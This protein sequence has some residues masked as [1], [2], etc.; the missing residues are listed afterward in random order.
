MKCFYIYTIFISISLV[1]AT[2]VEAGELGT[3][4]SH[5][6]YHSGVSTFSLPAEERLVSDEKYVFAF[7]NY[8]YKVNGEDKS[9]AAEKGKYG[10]GRILNVQGVLVHVTSD[11]NRL[12]HTA[13]SPHLRGT[14]GAAFPPTPWIALVRRGECNFEDKVKHVYAFRAAGIIIY[15]DREGNLDKMKLVDKESE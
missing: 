7:I 11:N 12:D 15:N 8:T 4:S 5:N 6:E 2:L 14:N 3:F 10:E 9:F 1:A 13:C